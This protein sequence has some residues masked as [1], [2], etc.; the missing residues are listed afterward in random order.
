MN[1]YSDATLNSGFAMGFF[2]GLIQII[3]G[4]MTSPQNS[5]S[6]VLLGIL[7]IG[8]YWV[9]GLLFSLILLFPL[10]PIFKKTSRTFSCLIFTL[11]G[12]II[13]IV[14]LHKYNQISYHAHYVYSSVGTIILMSSIGVVG[15]F[16]AWYTLVMEY[17]EK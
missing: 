2:A 4:L 14:L 8:V 11:T 6:I 7:L 5:I 13:P 16:T 12:M 10:R 3:N 15:A 9:I 1:E 17:N